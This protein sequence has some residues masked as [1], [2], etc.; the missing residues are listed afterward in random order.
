MKS[1][2][3][4]MVPRLSWD[5]SCDV[6]IVGSGFAGLAAAVE[7]KRAGCEPDIPYFR[8]Q[9]DVGREEPVF[10]EEKNEL[11]AMLIEDVMDL[12]D[13]QLWDEMN[14]TELEEWY[15]WSSYTDS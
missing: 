5:E 6:L 15:A 13:C 1:N 12:A 4:E 7:A 10:S 9:M 11:V 3:L 2:A 8:Y 14:D